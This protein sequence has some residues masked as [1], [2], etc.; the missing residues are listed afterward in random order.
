MTRIPSPPS[1]DPAQRPPWLV[2]G[3]RKLGK[4]DAP[5]WLKIEQLSAV[6]IGAYP[7]VEDELKA[8][9]TALERSTDTKPHR[10]LEQITAATTVETM[11]IF[12]WEVASQWLQNGRRDWH[13]PWPLYGVILWGKDGYVPQLMKEFWRAIKENRK[14]VAGHLAAALGMID[15]TAA[16]F[17]LFE[18]EFA[19]QERTDEM[20]QQVQQLLERA[21][22]KKQLTYPQLLNQLMPTYGLAAA[23]RFMIETPHGRYALLLTADMEPKLRDE[24]GRLHTELPKGVSAAKQAEWEANLQALDAAKK[25]QAWRLERAMVEQW[26][27]SWRDFDQFIVQHPY[28]QHVAQLVVWGLYDRRGRLRQSFRLADDLSFADE[29]DQTAA[30]GE[31]PER[32]EKMRALIPKLL[33]RSYWRQQFREFPAVSEKLTSS[34]PDW[35]SVGVVHPLHLS[36]EQR[37]YWRELFDDYELIPLFPQMWR[38]LS[39]ATMV[40]GLEVFEYHCSW[41]LPDIVMLQSGDYMAASGRGG[42][43]DRL[44]RWQWEASGQGT[45]KQFVRYFRGANVTAVLAPRWGAKSPPHAQLLFVNGRPQIYLYEQERLK[46]ERLEPFVLNETF[47]DLNRLLN[48]EES[49]LIN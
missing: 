20:Q 37:T 24:N 21:A 18:I 11:A 17:A 16:L 40:T 25:L 47:R 28:M 39:D 31:N 44:L 4:V 46:I 30:P 38:T 43:Y 2:R 10:F 29:L 35:L 7:L 41:T 13:R 1:L 12:S 22:Q 27:W 42:L 32:I 19:L 3:I 49:G 26:R 15:T 9:V 36:A 23:D 6:L 34:Q 14:L 8:M 45:T 5:N 48:E 33:R